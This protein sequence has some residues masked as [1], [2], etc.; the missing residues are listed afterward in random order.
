MFR[1]NKERI[2]GYVQPKTAVT[3]S[4]NNI[5]VN[6]VQPNTGVGILEDML[7]GSGEKNL[8][9]LY[10]EIYLYDSVSG[11]TVDLQANLP[12]STFNLTGVQDKKILRVYEESVEELGIV[13]LMIQLSVSYM[14][15][16][17]VIG[18]L[19]FSEDRGIFTDL[20]IFNPD[21]C[22]VTPI[23]VR[24]YDPKVDLKVSPEMK[25]FLRS[26]DPRDKEAKS[27]IPTK[28]M[29]QL[30][31]KSTV[32]LEPLNTLYLA[33]SHVPGIPAISSYTRVL[34][35]WLIEKALMRGTIIGA[36]RRQRSILHIIAG[37]EEWEPTDE[38]LINLTSLFTNAD[39]DPQGAVVATR[40]AIELSEV[41]SGS[42]F[43]KV[44]DEWDIFSTA[45]MR[46]LGVNEG[47]LSGETSYA[48]MEIALSVFIEN[49][50][51]FREF[52]TRNVL[53]DKVFLV[54][55]KYH[56]FKHRTRAELDHHI[57]IESKHDKYKVFGS[58]NLAEASQYIIP[59]VLWHKELTPRSDTTY[60]EILGTA[61][62]KGIPI[63]LSM[64]ASAA[65][66]DINEILDSLAQDIE[67][68]KKINEYK[69]KVKALGGEE[70]EEMFGKVDLKKVPNEKVLTGE[71]AD[72]IVDIAERK[73]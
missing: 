57:R 15:L 70:E 51:N 7:P 52:M 50:K 45:K 4:S 3:S 5:Q 43:W 13:N 32:Q 35:I 14:V 30:L 68:R 36:W 6:V 69:E 22:L 72:K 28:L 46:A 40:K 47:F 65:G 60:M 33:R 66:L 9:D 54:L 55:A 2:L 12:W 27:E 59:A 63:P 42:D 17:K 10:R 38:Q 58:K 73:A 71:Q 24:G 61:Q 25:K 16:G 67:L 44:S 18:S 23:P 62:E 19:L 53:Y 48:T 31:N 8:N 1:L 64:Y 34:P 11:P 20:A 37:D 56:G 49:L 41:R 21:D 26:T 29:A 39:Q